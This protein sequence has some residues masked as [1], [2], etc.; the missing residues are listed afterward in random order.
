[1]CV[2]F[3]RKKF[4]SMFSLSDKMRTGDSSE[5]KFGENCTFAYNQL[6]IDVWTME[7]SG[8]LDR[9]LLFET[10][11]AKL[12]PVNSIIRLLQEYKGVFV[13]ICQV[14][15]VVHC[16]SCHKKA[17]QCCRLIRQTRLHIT[18]FTHYEFHHLLPKTTNESG[19]SK[20]PVK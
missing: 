4:G 8:K 16:N 20:I 2:Y 10:T 3:T 6:E 18:Q 11:A 15:A 7:R 19:F 17:C 1:M 14:S 13:F 5:C 9:S 12:D